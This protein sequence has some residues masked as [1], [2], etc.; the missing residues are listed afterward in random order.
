MTAG[1][2]LRLLSRNGFAVS[3]GR[4]P[5]AFA[6]CCL[7][8]F[9][10]AAALLQRVRYGRA[11]GE[12]AVDPPPLFIVGHW[13]TGTTLLHE[14][15]SL[16][17]Q[18]RCP[19]TYECMAPAHFLVTGRLVI[20]HLGALLPKQRPLDAMRLRWD[21][22][23]EDEFAL[24]N[25]G[26]LSAYPSWAFS[27]RRTAW[28]D[29]LDPRDFA[30]RERERWEDTLRHFYRAVSSTGAG[31]L[32]LKA[33]PHTARLGLLAEMFPGA[34]FVHAVRH[35]FEMVPSFLVAWRRMAASVGLQSRLRPDLD[36]FL[37][38][39]GSR[40]YRRFDD[41]RSGLG[42]GRIIDVR[43]EDLIADPAKELDRIYRSFGLP[44]SD[45]ITPIVARYAVEVGDYQTNAHEAPPA[46]RVRIA[47]LWATYAARYGYALDPAGDAPH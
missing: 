7:S 1:P 44:H 18:F 19:T 35:P 22:P 11:I 24:C 26:A 14:L 40:L 36:D 32:V 5:M 10:S 33:P 3:P 45:R 2:W 8:V 4:L 46:L 47:G 6:V 29:L 25:R 13:R 30:P 27:H 12:A 21:L 34:L 42:P 20:R 15:L 16:D 17:P 41:D 43:Y 28:E 31:R 23:Q 9:N 39:L 37:I 38:R